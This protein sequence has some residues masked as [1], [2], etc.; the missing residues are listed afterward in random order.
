[1]LN[2]VPVTPAGQTFILSKFK[3]LIS[4][5]YK[6]DLPG[7]RLADNPFIGFDHYAFCEACGF[8]RIVAEPVYHGLFCICSDNQQAPAHDVFIVEPRSSGKQ[9][10]MAGSIIKPRQMIVPNRLPYVQAIIFV[11]SINN[12]IHD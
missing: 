11:L 3:N 7:L 1:M 12:K 2:W 5:Y 9:G 6:I 8:I 10:D 4:D